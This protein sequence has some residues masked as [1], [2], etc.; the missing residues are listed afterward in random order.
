MP[1]AVTSAGTQTGQHDHTLQLPYLARQGVSNICK[2][3]GQGFKFLSVVAALW[4]SAH[5]A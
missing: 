3:L 2:A 4:L 5:D 1:M